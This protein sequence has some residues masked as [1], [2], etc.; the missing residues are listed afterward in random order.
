MLKNLKSPQIP[1]YDATLMHFYDI[2]DAKENKRH[3]K[4]YTGTTH[5]TKEKHLFIYIW[6]NVMRYDFYRLRCAGD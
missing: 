6:H 3:A 2:V 4:L 1:H 5:G